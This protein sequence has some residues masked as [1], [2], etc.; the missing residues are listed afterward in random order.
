MASEAIL[1]Q[2]DLAQGGI[3]GAAVWVM[4]ISAGGFTLG[5][6]VAGR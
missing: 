1:I 6:R 2:G 4:A 5:N 3:P